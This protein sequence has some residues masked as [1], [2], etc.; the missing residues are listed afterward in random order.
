MKRKALFN[1][2]ILC[3]KFLT[4]S[5]NNITISRLFQPSLTPNFHR[6]FRSPNVTIPAI[7]LSANERLYFAY[8]SNLWLSQM[9]LRCPSSRYIGSASLPGYRWQINER[10]Y[11]NIARVAPDARVQG[12]VYDISP[13]DEERLDVHE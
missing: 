6:T 11:A 12:L 1:I 13:T 10:G 4:G 9:A 2:Y 5:C 3:W 7:Q 8:G